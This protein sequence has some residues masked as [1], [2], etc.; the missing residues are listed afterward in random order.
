MELELRFCPLRKQKVGT[1]ICATCACKHECAAA[2]DTDDEVEAL[3]YTDEEFPQT[4]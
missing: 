4:K 1:V 3:I 2:T